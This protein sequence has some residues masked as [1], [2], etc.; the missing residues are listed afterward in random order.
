MTQSV[1]E[2]FRFFDDDNDG[3]LSSQEAVI[4]VQR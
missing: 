3:K 1:A 4:M 2:A